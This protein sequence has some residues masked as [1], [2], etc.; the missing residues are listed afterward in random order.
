MD[1]NRKK[2]LALTDGSIHVTLQMAAGK[3]WPSGAPATEDVSVATTPVVVTATNSSTLAPA[4]VPTPTPTP[5]PATATTATA[6]ATTVATA[7][8]TTITAT[9][10]ATTITATAAPP[11]R[12]K[13]ERYTKA[14]DAVQPHSVINVPKEH[15]LSPYD[16]TAPIAAEFTDPASVAATDRHV[17]ELNDEVELYYM[18]QRMWLRL[19]PGE[20]KIP[21]VQSESVAFQRAWGKQGI[22][23]LETTQV[24]FLQP[25][26]LPAT[27][28]GGI[29]QSFQMYAAA[30]ERVMSNNKQRHPHMTDDE[31][32][33]LQTAK[34]ACDGM[35]MF[36]APPRSAQ[37]CLLMQSNH[38]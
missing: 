14:P 22:Q 20:A 6:T 7:V 28:H 4:P 21:E 17:Q 37:L 8:A 33:L 30:L 27:H 23:P 25:N 24:K 15:P 36:S 10:V 12:R 19:K 34:V 32:E 2:N 9:A 16:E 18:H 29:S 38:A 35:Q 26:L 31:L 1:K 3:R 11:R 13:R 5:T